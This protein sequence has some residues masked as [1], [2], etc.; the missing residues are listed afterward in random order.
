MPLELLEL[1]ISMYRIFGTIIGAFFFLC[2]VLF[3][4]FFFFLKKR[5]ENLA[6]EITAKT[7]KSYDTRLTLSISDIEIRKELLLFTGK[8]SIETQLSVYDDVLNLFLLYRGTWF[9]AQRKSIDKLK[10]IFDSI[11]DYRHKIYRYSLF[12]GSEYYSFLSEASWK[13]S[14]C[15]HKQIRKCEN[16]YIDDLEI[17]GDETTIITNM[18][19]A[20]EYLQ[21][22]LKSYQT[23]EQYDFVENEKEILKRDREDLFTKE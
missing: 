19:K 12:L 6:D 11:R 14:I 15:T 10:E 23:I 17:A 5:F 16:Y 9:Y 8:K 4:F 1:S 7:L 2:I 22:H 20:R 18:D 21:K 3:C 13:M